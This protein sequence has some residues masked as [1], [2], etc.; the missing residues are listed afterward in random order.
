MRGGDLKPEGGVDRDVPIAISLVKIAPGR[1]DPPL[2]FMR[3]QKI[4][5]G[6]ALRGEIKRGHP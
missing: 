4:E 5:G 1:R 3:F 6:K 2:P